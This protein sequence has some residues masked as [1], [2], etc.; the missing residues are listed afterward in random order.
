M[1]IPVFKYHPDPLLSGSIE[2]SKKKCV[3]CKKARGYIYT[4]PT[5]CEE[6]L[7]RVI[8]PWCISDGT[9]HAKYDATFV[10]ESVFTDDIPAAVIEEITQRTPGYSSWQSERWLSCCRD[11]MAFLEPVGLTEIRRRYAGLEDKVLAGISEDLNLSQVAAGRMLESLKRDAG[12]TAYVFQ[13][14][15]C[16]SYKTF[17]DGIFDISA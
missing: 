2:I 3:C 5:Y 15:R 10:D 16:H 7:E 11:A 17:V 4:G 1:D 14:L 13:C 9:A 12:P 8:C 6:D